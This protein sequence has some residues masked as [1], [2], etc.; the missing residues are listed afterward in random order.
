MARNN[1][2]VPQGRYLS[3]KETSLNL[4]SNF[5]SIST[6]TATPQMSN[7]YQFDWIVKESDD[8]SRE[9]ESEN[10]KSSDYKPDS[11]TPPSYST[12]WPKWR[13]QVA[14]SSSAPY[15]SRLFYNALSIITTP[16]TVSSISFCRLCFEVKTRKGGILLVVASNRVSNLVII[17]WEDTSSA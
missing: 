16:Q 2:E 7:N 13:P 12:A 6:V 3:R 9:H 8:C 4:L 10:E 14:F 15:T 17:G 5:T 1:L 11:Q